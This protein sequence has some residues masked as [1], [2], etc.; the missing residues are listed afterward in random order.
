MSD[1][2]PVMRA[3]ERA[4][5]SA[6][7]ALRGSWL[8]FLR[9]HEWQYVVTLTFDPSH[10]LPP[11]Y[12][13]SGWHQKAFRQLV[14]HINEELYGLRWRRKTTHK[15]IVWS[16]VTEPHLDG[17]LHIH[18]LIKTPCQPSSA[19]L[20]RF[21]RAWWAAR[22]GRAESN[23]PRS[24]EAVIKYL[25]KGVRVNSHASPDISQNFVSAR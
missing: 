10:R 11:F 19:K 5:E 6:S 2:Y 15:G 8:E 1:R 22:Y 3:I 25:L 4:S 23:R 16:F 17:R 13:E 18:A 12:S 14:R 9:K 7:L 21:I 24:Q 20:D